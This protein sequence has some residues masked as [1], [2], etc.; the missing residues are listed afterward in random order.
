MRQWMS[1]WLDVECRAAFQHSG[2]SRVEETP[3][4]IGVGSLS[5]LAGHVLGHG[6]IHVLLYSCSWRLFA[7]RRL[8]RICVWF[9]GFHGSLHGELTDQ[10]GTILASDGQG[11]V[12]ESFDSAGNVTSA[13]LYTPYGVSRYSSGSSPTSHGYTGQV[14]DGSTGLD[15]YNARYYDPV[16]GQFTSA[17]TVDDGLNRY[18]Y[19]AGNPTTAT[20]PS[21]HRRCDDYPACTHPGGHGGGGGGGTHGSCKDSAY[22]PECKTYYDW[23]R[24]NEPLRWDALRDLREQ[25]GKLLLSAGAALLLSSVVT[26]IASHNPVAIIDSLLDLAEGAYAGYQ[27][28]KLLTDASWDNNYATDNVLNAITFAVAALTS[29]VNTVLGILAAIAKLGWFGKAMEEAVLPAATEAVKLA[30]TGG[31]LAWV[32]E[33]II[34]AAQGFV[35]VVLTA[36]AQTV[37]AA[38]MAAKS[39]F[40]QNL[41]MDLETWCGQHT[42]VCTPAPKDTY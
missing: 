20:D 35:G 33:L 18:S 23:Q 41:N 36:V 9:G 22:H 4:D 14:A 16:A 8:L 40:D 13:Q 10:S 21:G 7:I 39:E 5:R 28:Y 24:Q 32:I 42:G 19:V 38:A 27:G 25:A 31:T 11:T 2:G 15:Y 3:T 34:D 29:A 1:T 30:V 6:W 37:Y 17:D 26:I 12:A